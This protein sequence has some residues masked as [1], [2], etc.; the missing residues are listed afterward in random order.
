MA[1]LTLVEEKDYDSFVLD[2]VAARRFAEVRRSLGLKQ[3]D[4]SIGA[5]K[6]G[7]DWTR[8]TV[9]AIERFA[10]HD[11]SGTRR[12]TLT[13]IFDYPKVLKAA[14][15]FA[16]LPYTKVHPAWFFLKEEDTL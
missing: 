6:V 2:K 16:N 3:T 11:G 10:S 4:V 5:Q 13:E 9:H 7:L 1:N 15:D 12:L 8:H 14:C